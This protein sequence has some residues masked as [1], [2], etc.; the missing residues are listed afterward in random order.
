MSAV[1]QE[2][3]KQLPFART[4][5]D[6]HMELIGREGADTAVRDQLFENWCTPNRIQFL[7]HMGEQGYD[8]FTLIEK[9]Q[10]IHSRQMLLNVARQFPSKRD[11]E[12]YA[13]IWQNAWSRELSGLKED[14][15]S[16]VD[17]RV[18]IERPIDELHDTVVN[19]RKAF[20]QM[21]NEHANVDLRAPSV[22]D[23]LLRWGVF[24]AKY[25]DDKDKITMRSTRLLHFDLPLIACKNTTI[26]WTPVLTTCLLEGHEE[27]PQ[28][29]GPLISGDNAKAK[30]SA[31]IAL[32]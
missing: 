25:G 11:V 31:R 9:P 1:Q 17:Y 2:L 10:L 15:P 4:A 20:R 13:F 23:A 22:L 12:P 29:Y 5:Y 26:S 3:E 6:N 21:Q 18:I 30:I 14:D 16:Q 7:E 32:G 27:D 19:Q 8:V 24:Y 28:P